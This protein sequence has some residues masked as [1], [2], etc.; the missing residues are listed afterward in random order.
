MSGVDGLPAH[1]EV[2][3]RLGLCALF[4]SA[5]RRHLAY[6]KVLLESYEGVGVARTERRFHTDDRALLVLL[7]VPDF[8]DVAARL[9]A[10]F[11]DEVGLRVEDVGE[12]LREKLRSDLA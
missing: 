11:E 7:L 8:L 10:L 2:D 4:V 12:K 3:D 1:F 5:P 6:I 9:V